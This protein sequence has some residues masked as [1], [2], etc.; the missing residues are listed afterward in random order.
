MKKYFIIT[1]IFVI[2][3]LNAQ[4]KK[5]QIEILN[6]RIDSLNQIVLKRDNTI[7]EKNTQVNALNSTKAA[8]ESAISSLNSNI[9][10][11]T[12]EIQ[13]CTSDTKIQKEEITNL[14]SQ[15]KVKTDSL[16]LHNIFE[17]R[18][19]MVNNKPLNL[20][21]FEMFEIMTFEDVAPGLATELIFRKNKTSEYISFNEYNNQ[22]NYDV[23]FDQEMKW[24]GK[25]A[26]LSLELDLDEKLIRILNRNTKYKV[27]YCY[28]NDSVLWRKPYP[29]EATDGYYIVDI[30][31]MD[32]QFEREKN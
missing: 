16:E 19:I 9:S 10:K 30:I 24:I 31:T 21:P 13:T 28:F 12:V 18:T 11:L 7:S 29:T 1:F 8:L 5:K 6:G 17:E 25:K 4:S 20:N 22:F 2:E 26:I 3:L 23:E 32:E 14:K 15:L 27:I